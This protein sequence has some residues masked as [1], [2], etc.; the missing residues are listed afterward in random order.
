MEFISPETVRM[1]SQL[2]VAGFPPY[3]WAALFGISCGIGGLIFYLL[4]SK[5]KSSN[6]YKIG[7]IGLVVLVIVFVAIGT[8]TWEISGVK[9]PIDP[10][11]FKA[12]IS[13]NTSMTQINNFGH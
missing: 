10:A 6:W 4:T 7:A 12:L 2:V 5:N 8:K 9:Y 13:A 3:L 11:D 1:M